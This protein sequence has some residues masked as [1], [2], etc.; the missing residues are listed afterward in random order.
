M[1]HTIKCR[2]KT[3][4]EMQ[5]HTA[6]TFCHMAYTFPTHHWYLGLVSC[7]LMLD[8]CCTDSLALLTVCATPCPAISQ[9]NL[10]QNKD[11]PPKTKWYSIVATKAAEYCNQL[12]AQP[13]LSVKYPCRVINLHNTANT[14]ELG[15]W[16]LVDRGF[17]V[18]A[19][20]SRMVD[21]KTNIAMDVAVTVQ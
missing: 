20:N 13:W 12:K 9:P 2:R 4:N 21:W 7:L 10:L 1:S 14:R 6:S 5:E 8:S 11:T 18:D 15:W 3:V 19:M 16:S 17:P